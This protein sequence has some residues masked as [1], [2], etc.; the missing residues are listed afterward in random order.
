[1]NPFLR[2][3]SSII[4]PPFPPYFPLAHHNTPVILHRITA[5]PTV[6][7]PSFPRRPVAWLPSQGLPC[8]LYHMDA[9]PPPRRRS[10]A[11]PRPWLLTHTI[12]S[13][14]RMKWNV[15]NGFEMVKTGVLKSWKWHTS[16]NL[17]V[18]KCESR[19]FFNTC[20]HI[21]IAVINMRSYF[22]CAFCSRLAFFPWLEHTYLIGSHV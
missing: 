7:R 12:H 2:T 5:F 13:T 1:M 22:M 10:A 8:P 14:S 11:V 18:P 6:N 19:I 21:N 15:T 17:W 3:T 20:K 4:P 9:F 16:V